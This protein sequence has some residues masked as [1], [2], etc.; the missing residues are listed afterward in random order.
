MKITISMRFFGFVD[1]FANLFG[2][3]HIPTLPL[4]HSVRYI[5]PGEPAH[6]KAKSITKPHSNH[7][8]ITRETLPQEKRKHNGGQITSTTLIP[9]TLHL[10]ALPGGCPPYLPGGCFLLNGCKK[11]SMKAPGART[12]GASLQASFHTISVWKKIFT[13]IPLYS[14]IPRPFA[15][16]LWNSSQKGARYCVL[17]QASARVY[18]RL[19]PGACLPCPALAPLCAGRT[20]CFSHL[21]T[22]FPCRFCFFQPA[23]C[24]PQ[25]GTQQKPPGATLFCPYHPHLNFSFQTL[26]LHF[27]WRN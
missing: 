13:E 22:F 14:S 24:A 19:A 9:Q 17:F 1:P 2:F 23:S 26:V 3:Y 20:H 10:L 4:S 27:A 12:I 7:T 21:F 8:V 25:H 11:K 18:L 5:F 16:L 15:L 6:S